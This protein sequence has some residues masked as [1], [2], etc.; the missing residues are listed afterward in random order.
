MEWVFTHSKDGELP[1]AVKVPTL[2]NKGVTL[3]IMDKIIVR[4]HYDSGVI[5]SV[6]SGH[7]H[8]EKDNDK[9]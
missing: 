8:D 9:R 2:V 1:F 3:V 7:Y 6:I 4:L 5:L